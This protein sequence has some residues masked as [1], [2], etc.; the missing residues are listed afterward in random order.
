MAEQDSIRVLCVDDHP[1][2]REGIAALVKSQRD[3]KL[4]A[5]VHENTVTAPVNL[6]DISNM[7]GAFASNTAIGV[8][9]IGA[10]PFRGVADLRS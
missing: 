10:C 3:M 2:L 8:R 7:Q 5:Q 9:A 6:A 1:L 4:L